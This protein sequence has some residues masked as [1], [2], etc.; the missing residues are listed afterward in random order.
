[1]FHPPLKERV[2]F[3][4]DKAPVPR[5]CIVHVPD[6][7][8]S[9]KLWSEERTEKAVEAVNCNGVS[10]RRA[11]ADYN[12][13][14]STLYDRLSGKVLPGSVCGAPKYLTHSE[15]E[16]LESFL[17]R[18]A[19][20]GFAKTR[21]EVLVLVEKLM[22]SRG[23]TK[24]VTSGWWEGFCRRH[25]KVALRTP[26]CLS[27][28]RALATNDVTINQYLDILEE[29]LRE[30]H[31]L[32]KP[33]QIFNLDETGVPLDPKPLKI[34]AARGEK[35]PSSIGSGK[36]E[37]I[38]VVA[39]ISAGG[40]YLPPMIIWN[41][42]SLSPGQT[43]GEV[44]GTLHGFSP[45]GW[46]DQEL[47]QLWF[48]KHFLRYAPST[49]PLFLLLDGHSS[50]YSPDT[51]RLAAREKVIVFTFPPNTT[52]LSQPLDKGIFGPL[53]THWRNECHKYV[54]ENPDK[55]IN[56][57]S[58]CSLFSNAWMKTMTAS[59]IAHSFRTTGVYPLNRDANKM[60]IKSPKVTS[61]AKDCG[62][63]YSTQRKF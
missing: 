15:E 16:E 47:F 2:F 34:V 46:I 49:R 62:L 40:N 36:K 35:C 38:T 18:C 39:C 37:Q 48:C 7:P 11:A 29:A 59:N 24:T 31:M 45:K 19:Q 54:R 20:I 52:H 44:P 26:A 30:N 3:L 56:K 57:Y 10:V 51:I 22:Q 14:K 50:H 12:I 60:P 27:K 58:F 4:P 17:I 41:T 61:L 5:S 23:T 1:M 55:L 33:C 63:A 42:K 13:P 21:S 53:K 32:D 8:L 9:C 28:A 6:K 43:L 25:P